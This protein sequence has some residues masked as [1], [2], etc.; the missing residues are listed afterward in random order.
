[1]GSLQRQNAS[2]PKEFNVFWWRAWDEAASDWGGG[3]FGRNVLRV[4]F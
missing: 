2:F 4:G 1:M 3:R